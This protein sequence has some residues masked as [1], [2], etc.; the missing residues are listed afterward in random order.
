MKLSHIFLLMSG[1]CCIFYLRSDSANLGYYRSL[2]ERFPRYYEE[3]ALN[4]LSQDRLEPLW[5]MMQRANHTGLL[6]SFF[7]GRSA[8]DLSRLADRLVSL[9]SGRLNMPQL[10]RYAYKKIAVG[11]EDTIITIGSLGGSLYSFVQI[12]LDLLLR[13]VIDE[14]LKLQDPHVY[15]VINGDFSAPSPYWFYVLDLIASLLEQNPQQC[16]ILRGRLERFSYWRGIDT[17]RKFLKSF[18]LRSSQEEIP[19]AEELDAF[20]NSLPDVLCIQ[21]KNSKQEVLITHHLLPVD[22]IG[23]PYICSWISSVEAVFGGRCSQGFGFSRFRSGVAQW[24]LFSAPDFVRSNEMS[25]YLVIPVKKD[26]EQLVG[27]YR[28]AS[29]NSLGV[30]FT[31]RRYALSY[32]FELKGS[33]DEARLE[34]G[35]REFV[36]SSADLSG[37]TS[38]VGDSLSLGVEAVLLDANE[39]GSCFPI[40][41]RHVVFDD[42][43]IPSITRKNVTRFIKEY[44]ATY[45]LA[46][47]GSPTLSSYISLVEQKKLAVLFT[48][49][50][51]TQFRNPNIPYIVNLRPSFA[52]EVDQLLDYVFS[53][54]QVKRFAVVYQADA[55]GTP[56]MGATQQ[57]LQKKASDVELVALPYVRGQASFVDMNE[58]VKASNAEAI[59]YFITS[60]GPA[61]GFFGGDM[62]VFLKGR[63]VLLVLVD[64]SIIRTLDRFG[65]ASIYSSSVPNPLH[66]NIPMVARYRQY[67]S[68]SRRSFST[69]SLLGFIS[70]ELFVRGVQQLVKEQKAINGAECVALFEK[71][72]GV[73]ILGMTFS[74][75]PQIRSFVLP[76]WIH[77]EDGLWISSLDVG[78]AV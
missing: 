67:F 28:F 21:N 56:L 35:Q 65:V 31:E 44:G 69:H 27:L 16:L 8:V 66:S 45:L 70:G 52:R 29:R 64:E 53:R 50:G 73:D 78:G 24:G 3:V 77:Q 54:Y 32:G 25:G 41:F 76:V 23:H 49:S 57:Y 59:A 11:P 1:L 40:L 55:F 9:S 5:R 30:P 26:F 14:D 34:G 4:N 71:Y 37:G 74:F 47:Q 46:P 75:D 2:I 10:R 62:T 20:F 15:L 7:G 19:Y 68:Q 36:C 13:G 17:V 33:E 18:S 42:R 61:Q 58:L 72:Q 22:D 51:A 48:E 60:S 6:T 12:L 38:L 43:Y 63:R 39:R